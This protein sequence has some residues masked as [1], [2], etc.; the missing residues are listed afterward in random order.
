MPSKKG[1]SFPFAKIV[2]FYDFDFA[3]KIKIKK[4]VTR[5]LKKSDFF[6]SQHKILCFPIAFLI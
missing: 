1:K 3:I 2:K 6:T 5:F 4:I